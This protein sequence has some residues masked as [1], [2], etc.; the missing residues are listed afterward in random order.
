MLEKKKRKEKK[1]ACGAA[2]QIERSQCRHQKQFS[3]NPVEIGHKFKTPK[4]T[5]F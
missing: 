5:G 1:F 2:R 3:L 4:L